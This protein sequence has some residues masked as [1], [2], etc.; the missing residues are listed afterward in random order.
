M[1]VNSKILIKFPTRGRPEKFFDVL[2]KYISMATDLSRIAFLI[3]MDEDDPAM[4]N[5]DI[6][7]RLEKRKAAGVKLVYFYGNSKTKIQAVNADISKVKG[8]DVLLL[9]SDDMIPVVKGYDH[10]IRKD[11][12][13]HFRDSDGVLW[14]S[15]GGQDRINTLS[16]MGKKYYDRFG[17]IY[18]PDYISLWCDNEFTDV[19]LKLNKCYRSNKVIIE[20]AHPTYSK[21]KYDELYVKNESYYSV[22]KVTYDKRSENNFDLDDLNKKLFSILI[23]GVPDRMESLS[24]LI[25]KLEDQVDKNNLKGEVEILALIDNKTRTVGNKRQS[26]L[27]TCEG[28]FVAYLDDDDTI[29]DDYIPEIVSAIK[30]DR[31]VDVVSFNQ[32]TRINNDPPNIVY[33]GLQY[34][35]TEY[36]P[37]VPVYRKP[38]HMCAWNRNIAKQVRFKN[39]SLTEDWAWIEELCKLAKTEFHIDKILHYYLFNSTTTTSKL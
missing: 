37:G 32:E 17:Y 5:P 29:S 6:I 2:D 39:I 12:N 30:L 33:F 26:L 25:Q 21:E 28:R 22:D 23:L 7:S 8:W 35:N 24:K 16:I 19:S 10:V 3:S 27:D 18:H 9:A 38:F 13:D 34:E 20:H 36:Y 31:Y 11:M 1:T 14:Y 15:D 4:N